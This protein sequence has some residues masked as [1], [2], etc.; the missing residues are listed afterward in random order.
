MRSGPSSA[1]PY[2]PNLVEPYSAIYVN[3][4]VLSDRQRKRREMI[5]EHQETEVRQTQRPSNGGRCTLKSCILASR[6]AS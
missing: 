3:S 1:Y 4:A 5:A 6:T 2:S